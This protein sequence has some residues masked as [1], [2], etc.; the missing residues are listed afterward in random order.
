MHICGSDNM[1]VYVYNN[2]DDYIKTAEK[3]VGVKHMTNKGTQGRQLK[4]GE[5]KTRERLESCHTF[6]ENA[7]QNKNQKFKSN[8][9]ILRIIE[10]ET[11]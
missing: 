8:R 2:N 4:M 10:K 5:S 6:I 9:R 11:H 3:R 1:N 7:N